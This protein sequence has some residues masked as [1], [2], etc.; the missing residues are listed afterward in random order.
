MRVVSPGDV[1]DLAYNPHPAMFEAL[2]DGDASPLPGGAGADG[3]AAEVL[4]DA[5]ADTGGEHR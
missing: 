5:E 4:G 2:P 1:V 3:F